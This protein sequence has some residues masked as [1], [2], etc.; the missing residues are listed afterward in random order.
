MSLAASSSISLMK[1]TPMRNNDNNPQRVRPSLSLAAAR[2][3]E[4]PWSDAE[5]A[6]DLAKLS[7]ETAMRMFAIF[8]TTDGALQV[9]NRWCIQIDGMNVDVEQLRSDSQYSG[10][11]RD[12]NDFQMASD[13]VKLAGMSGDLTVHRLRAMASKLAPAIL[14][15]FSECSHCKSDE[16]TCVIVHVAEKLQDQGELLLVRE[17][18]PKDDRV[19]QIAPKTRDQVIHNIRPRW[20]AAAIRSQ[21]SIQ[22]NNNEGDSAS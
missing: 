15:S 2:L 14:A 5:V 20:S 17:G 11:A 19:W 8:G 18:G 7:D 13:A 21:D 10:S 12:T 4:R 1:E 3:A 22:P 16:P 6:R 9:N